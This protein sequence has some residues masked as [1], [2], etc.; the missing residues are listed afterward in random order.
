MKFPKL[1]E[2]AHFH[3]DFVE[4]G[5]IEVTLVMEQENVPNTPDSLA[6]CQWSLVVTVGDRSSVVRRSHQDFVS[7]DQQLHRC[8]YDRRFSQLPELRRDDVRTL[9]LGV[10]IDAF[11]TDRVC[12]LLLF[13]RLSCLALDTGSCVQCRVE[14]M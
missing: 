7:F 9:G 11:F 4:L 2:C 8:I 14:C 5:R 13:I 3:Y 12:L 1:E 6:A 10:C